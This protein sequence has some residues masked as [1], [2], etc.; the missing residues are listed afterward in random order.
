[1][2]ISAGLAELLNRLRV[3][4]D[5]PYVLTSRYGCRLRDINW[6]H[7]REITAAA[8]VPGLRPHDLRHTVA[9][10]LIRSKEPLLNVS[11]LLGHAS[12]KVTEA[13]YVPAR[14][15]SS[16]APCR[17]W[18]TSRGEGHERAEPWP[19]SGAE[20]HR[21][22]LRQH[23]SAARI[24]TLDALVEIQSDVRMKLVALR[25]ALNR[26]RMANLDILPT[27]KAGG[28]LNTMRTQNSRTVPASQAIALAA[29]KRLRSHTASTGDFNVPCVPPMDRTPEKECVYQTEVWRPFGSRGP[30][31]FRY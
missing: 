16:R 1:M 21:E 7:W 28:F 14:R 27:A 5:S 4:N 22:G 31:A 20:T 8:G 17:S 9:N 6:D 3:D 29:F 19:E 10:N 18:M 12:T 15:S 2:P 23:H 25:S 30:S 24:P 13:V 26:Q 11:R